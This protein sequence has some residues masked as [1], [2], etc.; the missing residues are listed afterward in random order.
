MAKGLFIAFVAVFIGTVW[1]MSEPNYFD[2]VIES[3]VVNDRGKPEF[4]A[5]INE[6]ENKVSRI[7][8]ALKATDRDEVGG[9]KFICG[10]DIVKHKKKLEMPFVIQ[11]TNRTTGE[12]EIRVK[13]GF[14]LNY[15][16]RKHYRFSI[17]AND[18]GMPRRIS[19]PA[20]VMIKVK[21]VDKFA[22]NFENASYYITIE[23]GKLYDKFLT[24]RAVD[25][26]KSQT[27]RDIC[28][29]NILTPNVPFEIDAD[30]NI[31][32]T[33]ILEYSRHRNF[34][35]KVVAKDCGGKTSKPVSVN[36]FIKE[37]CRNG[38]QGI[39][40]KTTYF[41][42]SG[43]QKVAENARLR[44]CD[45]TC[46]PDNVSVKMT[47]ATKHIGKGCDRDTFSITSQRK[48]CGASGESVDLLPPPPL[49]DWTQNLQTDDGHE[50]DQVF[51]FNGENAAIVPENYFNHTLDQQFTISTW[52]KHDFSDDY[53]TPHKKVEKEHILCMSDGEEMNRHH[54]AVFVHGEKLVLLLRREPTTEAEMEI[55]KP[56]EWRWHI[57]QIN[58]AEWH[59]Y[60]IS[61]DLKNADQN[62]VKLYID[63]KLLLQDKTVFEEIDDWPLHKS[64]KVHYTKLSVGACWQGGKSR[65]E[66]YF[67]GYL[68][69]LS[70]LKA[71]RESDRVIRC[72]NNCKE[73]LDFHAVG[74]MQTGSS[75][76]FN[77]EMTEFNISGKDVAEVEKLLHEVAY[78]NVRSFPTPGR[79]KLLLQTQLKC[80]GE[81]VTL[82]EVQTYVMVQEPP[83]PIITI[84]GSK[85][86]TKLVF[87]FER[88]LLVFEDI[89][90]EAS[91]TSETR[92]EEEED[93]EDEDKAARLALKVSKAMLAQE[94]SLK[95]PRTD[96]LLD[97]CKIEADPPLNLFYEHLSLPTHIMGNLGLEWSETNDG[98]VITNADT[99]DRYISVLKKI[100]YYHNEPSIL[101]SRSLALKCSSENQRFISN[102]FITKLVA[103]HK[104]PEYNNA[105]NV[106][107]NVHDQPVE[108]DAMQRLSSKIT[109]DVV[110]STSNFGMAAIIVVCIG[111]LL[112]MIILGVIRIRAVHR[113][114]QVVQVDE[115][116]EMEWDNSALNITVNPME[117]EVQQVFEYE[118]NV[119]Q[120]LRDDTDS[121][122]DGSD[123]HDEIDSSDEEVR[124]PG[125][126][127]LE[128]DDSTLSF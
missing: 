59:H 75:V 90:I 2:P 55:F 46:T 67:K 44:M 53:D 47:L 4:H 80:N 113:R 76:S 98:V 127:Q 101:N 35:M 23:E 116:Q 125:K 124:P 123:F 121:E 88:G 5:I 119:Q 87:E 64:S 115:K 13:E 69:G 78:V 112:F 106:Q 77:N 26:D 39:S 82:P 24:I 62:S 107:S 19:N 8:P 56:A 79:R 33:K 105:A 96:I 118:D 93:E 128:W 15:E 104:E 99:I 3:D 16:K 65:F 6:N 51:F 38:W 97:S 18:C 72:L 34:I 45:P 95:E 114:T 58:D 43:R 27:F 10:Y 66:H 50:S 60:V 100:H 20:V 91:K 28:G 73:S 68:A 14:K 22:P 117:Q 41:A 110:A 70:V 21:D 84:T 74:E 63:G 111:F 86:L 122:D 40:D 85:N 89:K 30:G 25:E 42:G 57:P 36:I 94:T 102:M 71:K 17:V 83:K 12:A 48:I 126:D 1:C 54:Y 11:V 31:R 81:T 52:M 103:V 7:R 61:V 32:N 9:A 29:Y 108:H 49:A 37:I 120:A 92:E 109:P